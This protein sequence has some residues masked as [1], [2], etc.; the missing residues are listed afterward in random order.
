MYIVSG[1]K[2]WASCGEEN[3]SISEGYNVHEVAL[4]WHVCYFALILFRSLL[5]VLK[6]TRLLQQQKPCFGGDTVRKED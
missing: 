3:Q 6:E 4:R 1:W 2:W 5:F